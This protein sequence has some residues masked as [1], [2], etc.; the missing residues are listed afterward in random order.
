MSVPV[1][2]PAGSSL[3][4]FLTM[5]L[6]ALRES[7][8]II[9]AIAA[10]PLLVP[11]F[12][13]LV[14]APAFG[15][16]LL[17]T[18]QLGSESYVQYLAPGAILTAMMLPFTASVSVAVERQSGFYDRMRISPMGPRYSNLARR[19]ADTT[20]LA[21]FATVMVLVSWLA[22]AEIHNWPMV[23]LLG[24]GMAALWG[25][26]YSGLSFAVCLR[27]GRAEIAEGILPI[28]YPLLLV[29]SAYVPL[30]Q[31]PGWMQT[32]ATYNPLTYLADAIRGA[33]VGNVE[34]R[35]L[36][37]AILSTL[38]LIAVTQFLIAR[39]ERAVTTSV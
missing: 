23:I 25:F 26:A 18:G 12:M 37:I 27:T 38:G 32:L 34:A 29:S 36:V 6:R 9:L 33:Y 11:I 28:F 30:D 4:V 5:Y 35:P 20:K 16:I 17:T 1:S 14:F 22:G 39:A 8:R 31:L 10:V 13:V 15:N 19:A 24:I 3:S 2:A 21:G 7:R